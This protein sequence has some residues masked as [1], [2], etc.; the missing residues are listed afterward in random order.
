MLATQ[1]HCKDMAS[2]QSVKHLCS[3]KE[4][5]NLD[6]RFMRERKRKRKRERKTI[7]CYAPSPD[8]PVCPICGSLP[9]NRFRFTVQN[10]HPTRCSYLPRPKQA[11]T[12]LWA[13]YQKEIRT[14]KEPVFL[15]R[16][17]YE[18]KSP[19]APVENG[20]RPGRASFLTESSWP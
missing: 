15:M 9:S 17:R 1:S 3:V 11:V 16:F 13:I 18:V 7:S 5:S 19:W 12:N 14:S 4:Q 10:F 6:G 20:R 2:N 8:L